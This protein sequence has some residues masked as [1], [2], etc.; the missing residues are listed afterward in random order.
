M[1]I[2]PGFAWAR[3]TRSPA[4]CTVTQ[5]RAPPSNGDPRG[6]VHAPIASERSEEGR[7]GG[8]RA[9]VFC[10]YRCHTA[11]DFR[12]DHIGAL[13]PGEA[14]R[15]AVVHV[16]MFLDRGHPR[17]AGCSLCMGAGALGVPRTAPRGCLAARSLGRSPCPLAMSKSQVIG[18]QGPAGTG[19]SKATGGPGDTWRDNHPARSLE[20]ASTTWSELSPRSL[21][22]LPRSCP[23]CASMNCAAWG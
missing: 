17:S 16:E 15:R 1:R 4:T 5:P 2:P 21:E 13:G 11:F 7:D 19:G 8:C 6:V 14:F 23:P 12:Q 18:H 9:L 20:L 3:I 10:N 22:R